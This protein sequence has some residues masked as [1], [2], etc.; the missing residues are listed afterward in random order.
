MSKGH[1]ASYVSGKRGA[2]ELAKTLIARGVDHL[3]F[4]L[5]EG[6]PLHRNLIPGTD[7][8]VA[9]CCSEHM[10]FGSTLSPYLLNILLEGMLAVS[11]PTQSRVGISEKGTATLELSVIGT[12]GHSS[13]PPA[14]SA[15]GILAAAVAKLEENQQ[16]SL[17]GKGPESAMFRY[18]AP[19]SNV[20]PPSA[21]AVI[22]HR[23][24]PAQSVAEVIAHDRKVIDDP[25]VDIRVKISREAHPVSPFGPTSIPFQMVAA[26]IRQIYPDAIVVPDYPLRNEGFQTLNCDLIY[27][28]SAIARGPPQFELWI[29]KSGLAYPG[30]GGV[31]TGGSASPAFHVSQVITV[32]RVR[33]PA[34]E[35]TVFIANTDTRWYLSFTS[36]LYRFLPTVILPSDVN[37]YHGNNERISIHHYY[38]AVS[39]Y[40]RLIKNAD[41]LIDQIVKLAELN[42]TRP[43]C[44]LFL[45]DSSDSECVDDPDF[46]LNGTVYASGDNNNE[47]H[48]N[49]QLNKNQDETVGASGKK[50][51]RS[52]NKRAENKNKDSGKRR[53]RG[54]PRQPNQQAAPTPLYHSR[55]PISAEKYRDLA[56]LCQKGIIPPR[57]RQEY[58]GLPH[59]STAK[60]TLAET[61]EEDSVKEGFGN[62]INLCRDRGLSPGPI[63][64]KSDTLPL[65]R[66]SM[67]LSAVDPKAF[68]HVSLALLAN[69][70]VTP[71]TDNACSPG[72]AEAFKS[73]KAQEIMLRFVTL[74]CTA[75][76]TMLLPAPNKLKRIDILQYKY[77]Q[78]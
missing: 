33:G 16:P 8:H 55:L 41:V 19:H 36:N 68:H 14:E 31:S 12:P 59:K 27:T 52:G 20:I 38:K 50:K 75:N 40:Y 45:Q 61:D 53:I 63:A 78:D 44:I 21:K 70:P 56:G 67:T 65:D 39:F 13:F 26:S 62:Q 46:V 49:I 72:N 51:D 57:C 15:I 66:L 25:R 23:V 30:V 32:C 28:R 4:V 11:D 34:S 58:L 1:E 71:Q 73:P 5:D 60:D 43:I 18:L 7:R 54:R 37:R 29:M 22:N 69:D 77:L 10:C 3:D 24:H 74:A 17:L 2:Q 6:F 9:M 35:L 48:R 47:S 42:H 76:I 64:Q